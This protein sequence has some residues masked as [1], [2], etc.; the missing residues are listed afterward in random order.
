PKVPLEEGAEASAEVKS[1]E[2]DIRT[3]RPGHP[4]LVKVSYHPRWRAENADGPYLLSPS[5]MM[6]I[7]RG[8]TARLVYAARD[9]SD[10]TGLVLT[11]VA[12]VAGLSRLARRAAPRT[13]VIPVCPTEP[14]PRRWGAAVPV[15][16]LAL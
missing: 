3:N 2:I 6:V 16:I 1:E 15:A 10:Y 7:P 9:R 14:P 8:P 5:L 12:A 4:L 13:L 11:V